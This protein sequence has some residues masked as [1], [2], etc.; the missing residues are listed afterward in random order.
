MSNVITLAGPEKPAPVARHEEITVYGTVGPLTVALT[1]RTDAMAGLIH[2]VLLGS[3]I[4]LEVVATLPDDTKGRAIAD[5][6]GPAVVRS[7][8]LAETEFAA[9][10][11]AC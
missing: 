2:V 10:P 5:F 1:R 8:E 11:E 3:A 9:R 7:A 4:G 6:V